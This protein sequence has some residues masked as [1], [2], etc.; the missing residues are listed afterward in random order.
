MALSGKH[1]SVATIM[2]KLYRDYP[3]QDV[4]FTDV[5]EWI[6]EAIAH[7]GIPASMYDKESTLT[8]V[9]G[10]AELPCDFY[11]LNMM[12]DHESGATLL[13]KT[14]GFS[15]TEVTD[16]YHYAYQDSLYTYK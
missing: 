8:F 1:V 15:F 12:K 2:E 4:D 9:D 14:S 3:F 6:G 11:S 13:P 16:L 10:R 7:L 5:V